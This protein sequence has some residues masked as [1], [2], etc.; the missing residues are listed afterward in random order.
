MIIVGKDCEGCM[1]G[2]VDDSS[3]S[4]TMINCA[5]RNKSYIWG[6]SIPCEDRRVIGK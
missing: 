2:T 4:K 3:K 5:A 1:H 6:Q